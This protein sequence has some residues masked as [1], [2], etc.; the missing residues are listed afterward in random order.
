MKKIHYAIL[1]VFSMI[2]MPTLTQAALSHEALMSL[3]PSPNVKDAAYGGVGIFVYDDMNSL[4]ALGPM[5]VF[6]AAGLR[7]FLI[8]K[9]AGTV[10][11]S[12]GLTINVTKGIAEVAKLGVLVIPGGATGTVMQTMDPDVLEWIRMIDKT[13]VYTTSVCTGSWILGSAGLLTGKKATSNWY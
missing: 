10:T 5:Q 6:S 2:L 7:P 1:L 3:T 11:A 9:K 4:D 12:N 13:T 8:A